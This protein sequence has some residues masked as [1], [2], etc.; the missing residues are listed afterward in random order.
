[1]RVSHNENLNDLSIFK[2]VLTQKKSARF[3]VQSNNLRENYRS[4]DP[5]YYS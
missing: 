4:E 5:S 3:P 2:T 1:M